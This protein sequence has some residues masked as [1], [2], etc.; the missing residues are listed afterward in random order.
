MLKVDE[1][2]KV[3]T[4]QTFKLRC[5]LKKYLPLY[6]QRKGLQEEKTRHVRLGSQGFRKLLTKKMLKGRKIKS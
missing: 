4:S 2:N 6:N 5:N 1:L 3:F